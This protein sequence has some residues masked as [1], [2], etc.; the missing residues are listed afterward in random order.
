MP[1]ITC[2]N[3]QCN[4]PIAFI[5]GNVPKVKCDKCGRVRRIYHEEKRDAIKLTIKVIQ[6]GR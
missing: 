5:N 4:H 6:S 3:K 2:R 1:V